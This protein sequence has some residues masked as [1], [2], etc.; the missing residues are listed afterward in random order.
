MGKFKA[1][2]NSE[3]FRRRF[4]EEAVPIISR[5]EAKE[6]NVRLVELRES[7]FPG[8]AGATVDLP[9]KS[10]SHRRNIAT[11]TSSLEA[12]RKRDMHPVFSLSP[13]P[14]LHLQY[15]HRHS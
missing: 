8:E 14:T 11:A 2:R 9:G 5:L 10:S 3:A 1:N 15:T 7:S 6:K 12:E 13:H 4:S